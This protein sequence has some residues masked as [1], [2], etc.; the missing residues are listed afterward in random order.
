MGLHLTKISGRHSRL[1]CREHT[2][3]Q[4]G[5]FMLTRSGIGNYDTVSVPIAVQGSLVYSQHALLELK[6]GAVML[7][8]I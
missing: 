3:F 4:K 2:P 6:V 8:I 5:T 7:R 1:F